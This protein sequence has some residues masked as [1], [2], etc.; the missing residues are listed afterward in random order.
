V[1]KKLLWLIF[2]AVMALVALG[3]SL[4][5]GYQTHLWLAQSAAA[6]PASINWS[7]EKNGSDRF[8]LSADYTF[9]FKGREIA[10]R[11]TF[12]STRY[13]NV[14]TAEYFLR[15][16]MEK[17]WTVRYS[18]LRPRNSTIN[19]FF[20]LKSCVYTAIVWCI[21]FYFIWLG[22]TVRDSKFG[23]FSLPKTKF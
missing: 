14:Q 20:P 2:L 11:T 19:H 15:K 21:L 23:I 13:R 10:G 7:I 18:P 12:P 22:Y 5:S 1:N 16:Q 9:S 3:F 6:A 8:I 4:R 17:R